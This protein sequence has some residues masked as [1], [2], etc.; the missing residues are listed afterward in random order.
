[1]L[2]VV[3]VTGARY[4]DVNVVIRVRAIGV[5]RG[6]RGRETA[7]DVHL[8][9]ED[10]VEHGFFRGEGACDL[11]EGGG[12][13]REPASGR[14][15][16]LSPPRTTPGDRCGRYGACGVGQDVV[17]AQRLGEGDRLG[18]DHMHTPASPGRPPN[19]SSSPGP[20]HCKGSCRRA[21]RA[22]IV[23]RRRDDMGVRHRGSMNAAGHQARKMGH[24]DDADTHRCQRSRE[25]A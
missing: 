4:G 12:D 16:A 13:R 21:D 23:G 14:W 10:A 2:C 17:R 19:S 18:R 7:G 9:Q 6:R 11:V 1:M 5:G 22:A 24:V 20:R 3:L 25:S 15:E 8:R